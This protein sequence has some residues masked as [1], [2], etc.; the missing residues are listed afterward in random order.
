MR[1]TVTDFRATLP[2]ILNLRNEAMRPRHW[3]QLKTE[4]GKDFDQNSDEFTLEKVFSLGLHNFGE[5]IGTLS[6][7][8][9]KELAIEMALK[10]IDSAWRT[11]DI[12]MGSYKD[13]YFKIRSTDD[14]FAQLED[15]VMAL[16]QMKASRFFKTFKDKITHWESV[17]SHM[18]NVV[19]LALAVQRS[20]MYLESIFM[21]S[22]D[23]RRQLP[24]ESKIFDKVNELQCTIWK[25]F[26][27]DSNAVN[28]T[29]QKHVLPGLEEMD[30]KL[31][32]VQKSLD[33][34]LEMKRQMFPRFYFLSNDDLLDI[35]GQQKDPSKVCN[36][37]LP[38]LLGSKTH[39][40]MFRRYQIP[41]TQEEYTHT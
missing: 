38:I 30:Q 17:L 24:K 20:W 22:E 3:S 33:Q 11:I 36:N 29:Q 14:L 32:V 8:A 2:L 35:L 31:S 1:E 4:I 13:S 6:D 12:E 18:S 41:T 28:A 5:F 26:N 21:T 34:Y 9:N 15:N 25:G 27:D 37:T 39:H 10:E 16:S 19:E 40:Q 7:T 23:I